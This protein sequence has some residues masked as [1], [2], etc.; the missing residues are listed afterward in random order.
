MK[1]NEADQLIRDLR[2][3]TATSM[4][5]VT[6]LFFALSAQPGIDADKLR[7][8]FVTLVTLRAGTE[9]NDQAR[10]ILTAMAKIIA[11]GPSRRST[12]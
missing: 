3:I 11:E 6:D 5:M 7:E 10:K 8:N 4:S 2:A 1:S 12:T 9:S